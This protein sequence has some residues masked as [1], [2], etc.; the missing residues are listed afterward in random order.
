[1]RAPVKDCKPLQG[2]EKVGCSGKKST[3]T[4]LKIDSE[5]VR[6]CPDA[7]FQ[8]TFVIAKGRREKGTRREND[9]LMREVTE[10]T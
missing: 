4:L 7:L 9:E 2:Q 3:E 5:L 1:M 6:S 10:A 8:L